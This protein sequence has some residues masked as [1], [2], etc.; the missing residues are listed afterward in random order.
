MPMGGRTAPAMFQRVVDTVFRKELDEDIAAFYLDDVLIW[1]KT[2]EEIALKAS[3]V[4]ARAGD[5]NLKLSAKKICCG[6]KFEFGVL[7]LSGEYFRPTN[8]GLKKLCVT[9]PPDTI[10]QMQSLLG[11]INYYLHYVPN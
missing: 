8:T 3:R 9:E 4:C 7:R 5:C 2:W 1:G 11:L 6:S 10:R